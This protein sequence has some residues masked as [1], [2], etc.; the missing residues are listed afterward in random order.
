M[1]WLRGSFDR[2]EGRLLAELLA[3][4]AE[5]TAA[6]GSN[7]AAANWTS[8]AAP[9]PQA[10]SEL[11]PCVQRYLQLADAASCNYTVLTSTQ[12]GQF[13]Y[14]AEDASPWQRMKVKLCASPLVPAFHWSARCTFK[15]LIGLRGFD[16]RVRGSGRLDWRLWGWLPAHS[17]N[18][19]ALDRTLLVR[20]LADAPGCPQAML[21]SASLQWETVPGCTSEAHAVLTHGGITV[22]GVF[23]FDGEGLVSS[24]R[25]EDYVMPLAG[26]GEELRPWLVRY[27]GHKRVNVTDGSSSCNRGGDGGSGGGSSGQ[28][29]TLFVPTDCEA[30]RLEPDGREVPYVRFQLD[31]LSGQR[32]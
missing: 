12:V 4:A 5:A 30:C 3:E 7:S 23:T 26:G 19:P 1:G 22:S 32:K 16:S 31:K 13:K 14:A 29:G 28:Q 24:F 11:P 2:L 21:P 27:R 15:P 17:A 25:T 10:L 9:Q 8:P 18:G 6:A 20:W